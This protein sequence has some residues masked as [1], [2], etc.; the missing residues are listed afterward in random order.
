MIM[1]GV[2]IGLL[3]LFL[4]FQS[5]IRKDCFVEDHI[6]MS[7]EIKNDNQCNNYDCLFV[8]T[9]SNKYSISVNRTFF[10]ADEKILLSQKLNL[11]QGDIIKIT[12]CH[13]KQAGPYY[14][15]NIKK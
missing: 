11:K 2:I 4:G 13:T 10:F 1:F 7:D 8:Q 12:W 9:I 6:F 5:I 15:Q 14:I 3:F